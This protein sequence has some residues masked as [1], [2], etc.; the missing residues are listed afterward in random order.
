MGGRF[1]HP[2]ELLDHLTLAQF[3][4][5]EEYYDQEPWGE[6]RADARQGVMLR[7][8]LRPHEKYQLSALP[9]VM[10][11]Y[12][13]P[14]R[15]DDAAELKAFMER[16]DAAVKPKEGGGYELTKT[17]DEVIHGDHQPNQH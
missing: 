11:P 8:L 17:L 13:D 2:D 10:W 7:Y 12:F 6:W 3:R 4:D 1:A 16:F 5:W 14:L 15:G 9:D